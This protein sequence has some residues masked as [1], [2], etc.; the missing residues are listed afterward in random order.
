M[1]SVAI[2]RPETH[3]STNTVGFHRNANGILVSPGTVQHCNEEYDS[4]HFDMLVGMQRDHFWYRG[5][6]RFLLHAVRQYCQ[7][8][9]QNHTG[10]SAIDMGG[11]CGGWL[12]YL[13]NHRPSQFDELAL[14]D[15]SLR[16]LELARPIVGGVVDRYQIDLKQLPW[17]RR[18][19]TVFLLDVLE[20]LPHDGQILREISKTLRPGGLLFVTT[21]ALDFFWSYN[22]ELVHHVRRYTRRDYTQL[23]HQAGLE[24]CR[25]RYFMTLLSPLLLLSRLKPPAIAQMSAAEIA[26]HQ[27]RTHRV[28]AFPV[29]QVL[30]FIFGMETPLSHWLPLPWGTSVLAVLRK[31]D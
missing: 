30:S 12:R 4:A 23:A 7:R 25:T 3:E 20:H 18:W 9:P 24:V 31:P 27:R 28:P 22:D 17:Q 11:G 5:R 10:M 29:N 21:P 1:T 14:G 2:R 16:A 15:S 26:E 8:Q 19:D 6:H 13:S